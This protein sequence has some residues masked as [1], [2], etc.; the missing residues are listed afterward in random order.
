[1]SRAS[2]DERTVTHVQSLI[3]DYIGDVWG[4]WD[5]WGIMEICRGLVLS[6][7]THLPCL[8]QQLRQSCGGKSGVPAHA[9]GTC[10]P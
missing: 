1:M 9:L 6:L 2:E 7:V 10:I 8:S 3:G 5:I 4:L